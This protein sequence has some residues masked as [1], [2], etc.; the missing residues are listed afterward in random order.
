MKHVYY[1]VL[2]SFISGK[3]TRTSAASYLLSVLFSLFLILKHIRD[4]K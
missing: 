3:L 2:L 4:Y 1:R